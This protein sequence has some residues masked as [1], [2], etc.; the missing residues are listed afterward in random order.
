MD[1]KEWAEVRELA[2][3]T[4]A[5]NVKSFMGW[6]GTT[7]PEVAEALG[8]VPSGVSDRLRGQTSFKGEELVV[9]AQ[10]FGVAVDDFFHAPDPR[11]PIGGQL[12]GPRVAA[13]VERM[14]AIE[15]KLAGPPTTPGP[16]AKAAPKP[17]KAR[18]KA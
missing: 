15:A 13:L 3:K 4:L 7:Q 8:L 18:P 16:P 14:D 9:L 6:T 12:I 11:L 2:A 17:R 1:R 5:A 10:M